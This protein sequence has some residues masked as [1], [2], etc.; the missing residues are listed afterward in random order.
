MEDALAVFDKGET[1]ATNDGVWFV[2]P[3]KASRGGSIQAHLVDATH[4][5][6]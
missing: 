4:V 3:D 1:L 6:R 5:H 2:T